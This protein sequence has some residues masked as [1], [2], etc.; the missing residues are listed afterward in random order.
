[1]SK[2]DRADAWVKQIHVKK[3]IIRA[4]SRNCMYGSEQTARAAGDVIE[5]ARFI[6]RLLREMAGVA[7]VDSQCRIGIEGN[8]A[9]LRTPMSLQMR[10]FR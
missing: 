1:M 9:I 10:S 7:K 5:A 8:S 3:L 4:P 2:F 6:V